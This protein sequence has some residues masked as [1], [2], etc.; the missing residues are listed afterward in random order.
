MILTTREIDSFMLTYQQDLDYLENLL[1]N[2]TT[3]NL[4]IHSIIRR[5]RSTFFKEFDNLVNW[6]FYDSCGFFGHREDSTRFYFDDDRKVICEFH[7]RYYVFDNED[8]NPRFS[9][10]YI[11]EKGQKSYKYPEFWIAEICRE[12]LKKEEA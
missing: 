2:T 10:S 3:D 8:S 9:G 11:P 6:F 12:I 7:D 1:V 5:I 4:I